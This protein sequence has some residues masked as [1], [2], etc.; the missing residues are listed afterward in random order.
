MHSQ[1]SLDMDSLHEIAAL[2]QSRLS[3]LL[4][5][6]DAYSWVV[7]IISWFFITLALSMGLPIAFLIV[8]DFFLWIYR[9]IFPIPA[10]ISR[11][12]QRHESLSHPVRA[13]S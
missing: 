7:T 10:N 5:V 3:D 6:S 1:S 8:F 13:K 2:L 9:L 11:G 4:A 12:R